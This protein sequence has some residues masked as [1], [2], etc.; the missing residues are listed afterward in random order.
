[1]AEM[2]YRMGM[3]PDQLAKRLSDNGQ[4]GAVAGDVLRS[5][6]MRL[7]GEKA[8]IVDEAGRPVYVTADEPELDDAD[9]EDEAEDEGSEADES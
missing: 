5:N 6:A 1:M 7:L 3:A 2:A 8:R 9:A 4:L